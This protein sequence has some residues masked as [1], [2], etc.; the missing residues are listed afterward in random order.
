MSPTGGPAYRGGV[1]AALCQVAPTSDPEHNLALVVDALAAAA[2]AGADL[3]VLPEATLARFGTPPAEVAQPLDGPWASE[4]RRLAVQAGLVAVV[5]TF[6][7]ADDGRVHNTLLVTGPGVEARYDKLH[8]FDAFGARESDL[9]APGDALVTVEVAGVR[10]GLATCYDV[11]FPPLFTALADVGADVVVLPAAWG[12]G[13]GKAEQ[14][15]LLVRA[16]ALD[17]TTW[18]LACD[19]AEPSTAGIDPHPRAPGG[20][21]RSTA[22]DPLGAVVDRLGAQPGVLVVD[23]DADRVREVRERLPVLRHARPLPR[24]A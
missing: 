1:R 22:V 11:R 13:P 17:A 2:A 7:P 5:G 24:R 15:D 4:V 14:W 8:L 20:I 12:D 19:Q 9:V 6:T 23:V 3:A 21:G 10:V 18:L 16:R